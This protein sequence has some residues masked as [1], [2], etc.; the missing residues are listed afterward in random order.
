M[1]TTPGLG[2]HV[3]YNRCYDVTVS[4]PNAHCVTM[5][6]PSYQTSKA[7]IRPL[8]KYLLN[9]Q[10]GGS[11][12]TLSPLLH[13]RM[14]PKF[15]AMASRQSGFR[16]LLCA[17]LQHP[18]KLPAT[19]LNRTYHQTS[20]FSA[21][22]KD[23]S[24]DDLRPWRSENTSSGYDQEAAEHKHGA[25]DPSITRPEEAK[26]SVQKEC[27]GS[28]LEYS[29]A[30]RDMSKTLDENMGGQDD[31]KRIKSGNRPGKKHGNVKPM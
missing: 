14:R 31:H 6:A 17:R 26:E 28:P 20:S 7:M 4:G 3:G 10:P 15:G 18:A 12:C 21:D 23:T 11:L 1:E 8:L 30:N 16:A 25:F 27:N 22:T 19:P 24:S 29:G 13:P 5:T 2:F 9:I